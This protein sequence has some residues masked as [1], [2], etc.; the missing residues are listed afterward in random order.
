MD[1]MR[2]QFE[3][4]SPGNTGKKEGSH[5]LSH[6]GFAG[7]FVQDHPPNKVRRLG[8]KTLSVHGELQP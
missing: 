8:L 3:H 7:S 2:S 6:T 1:D 4:Q 5:V